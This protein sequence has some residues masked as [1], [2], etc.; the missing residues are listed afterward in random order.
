MSS[1]LLVANWK[2]NHSKKS[3]GDFLS[4]LI[5]ATSNLKQVEVALAPVSLHLDFLQQKAVGTKLSIAA[6]NVFY[7]D[8]GAFTGEFSA[9]QLAE[10]GVSI[11][12]VGHSE[13]RRLFLEDDEIVVKKVAACLK[14]DLIPIACVGE[15]LIER[16]RG[17]LHD[18]IKRQ[19]LALAEVV[20]ENQEIILAYEPVW[21]IGTGLSAS[22]QQAEE[23]HALIR[24]MLAQAWGLARASRTR[25]LYGGSLTAQNIKEIVSM[26]NV[27]GALVGGASLQVGS[28]LA[29]VNELDS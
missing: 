17:Q 12:I 5:P 10:L 19:C 21:A 26:P 22:A 16:D 29:M 13:R 6:Q 24:Q 11:A 9:E 23:A 3:A 8:H 2:L 27:D 18:V 4:S 15:T 20:L 7:E 1:A 14:H 25:I 28:F